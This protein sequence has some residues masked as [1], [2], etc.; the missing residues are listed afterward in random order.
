LAP[1]GNV[2]RSQLF[3]A[4][5]E[6]SGPALGLLGFQFFPEP[7]QVSWGNLDETIAARVPQRVAELL[8]AQVFIEQVNALAHDQWS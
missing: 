5:N 3:A 6:G 4:D 1:E 2:I 8:D 7:P